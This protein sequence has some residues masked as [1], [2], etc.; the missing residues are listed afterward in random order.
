MWVEGIRLND[1]DSGLKLLFRHGWTFGALLRT[2]D[3]LFLNRKNGSTSN[4]PEML[5]TFDV[6]FL[7]KRKGSTLNIPEMLQTFE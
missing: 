1:V 2:F 6:L 3:V 7:S 5:W 4:V